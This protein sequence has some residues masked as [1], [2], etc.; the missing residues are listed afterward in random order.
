MQVR[1]KFGAAVG[2]LAVAA[3]SVAFA[4]NADAD[5]S[6]QT[7]DIVVVG[8]DTLQ[9]AINFALDG[10]PG[11][12]GGYNSTGNLNRAVSFDA[13]GD[14]NGRL[15]YDS[16]C[17]AAQSDGLGGACGSA[18]RLVTDGVENGSTT[19][20]SATAAFTSNDVN[21][22]VVGAGIPANT[23]IASVTDSQTAV[24]NHAATAT[25]TGVT[26]AIQPGAGSANALAESV[27]LRAGTKPVL[28]PNGSGKGVAALNSDFSSPGYEGL[29]T[30]SI[31]MA[32]MSRLPSTT[33]ESN[34][35][36]TGTNPCGGLH[37][38]RIA[39]DGFTMVHAASGYNGPA[40]LSINE[41]VS[42]Y[43]CA[44]TK[45]NQLPGNSGGSGNT[46]HPLIPQS[47]SGT[48]GAFLTDL[49]AAAGS[50]INPGSCVR[51][52]Q[53]HDPTGIYADGSPG[54]AIEPFSTG[55]IGLIN[56]TINASG[57]YFVNGVSYSGAGAA[58]GAYTAGFLAKT[59]AGNATDGNPNWS[60][61]R[62]LYLVIRNS[63]LTSTTPFQP[64]SSANW[65]SAIITAN[66]TSA[67]RSTNG[68][69]E[70]AAAGF[71]YSYLDCGVNPDPAT[72]TC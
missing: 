9:N 18:V 71:T 8:S 13:T 61:N 2:A 43:T 70:I 12:A 11:V 23:T 45:W 26:L 29:P 6:A 17:G 27:I 48:R 10:S 16:T 19:I 40:S 3:M 21:G 41:L 54:D 66:L 59:A 50:T 65:A 39:S 46:I 64:G 72:S 36:T 22:L 34:C 32:R 62:N 35:P 58:N 4:G 55:K 44:I 20:T 57:A 15:P 1:T 30:G 52:V 69:A 24:L 47:G 33:E 31:Q 49:S 38:Y 53:E 5:T 63:D 67:F 42:V 25:A 28:R 51:T 37:V 56:G 7:G 14:A 60:T 68:K